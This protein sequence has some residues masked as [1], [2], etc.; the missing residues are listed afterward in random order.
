M[1]ALDDI[2]TSNI[3]DADIAK[4]R[5]IRSITRDHA[6]LDID[7]PTDEQ[8]REQVAELSRQVSVLCQALNG[9]VSAMV[10]D[11]DHLGD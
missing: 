9:D 5:I 1:T 10:Y 8:V 4:A 3:P 6:Y 2:L 11:P 7:N